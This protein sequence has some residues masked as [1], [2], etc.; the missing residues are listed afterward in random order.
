MKEVTSLDE[1]HSRRTSLTP[2]RTLSLKSFT[3]SLETDFF[4]AKHLYFFVP[5]LSLKVKRQHSYLE[6]LT[7]N[8]LDKSLL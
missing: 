7:V 5:L 4:E 2:L 6:H 3:M 1:A 8:E